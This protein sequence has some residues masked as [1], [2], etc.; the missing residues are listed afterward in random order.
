MKNKSKIPPS[1]RKVI[2]NKKKWK[3]DKLVSNAR[4]IL[5]FFIKSS[6]RKSRWFPI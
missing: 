3:V 4:V 5:S 1:E 6:D 2:C